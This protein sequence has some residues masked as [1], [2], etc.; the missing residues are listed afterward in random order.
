MNE[1]DSLRKRG[2]DAGLAIL[3]LHN[4]NLRTVRLS[5]NSHGISD[6]YTIVRDAEG[7]YRGFRLRTTRY[8]CLVTTA[9]DTMSSSYI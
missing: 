8:F 6:I 7:A 1:G 2:Y 3:A 9:W 5:S 4:D